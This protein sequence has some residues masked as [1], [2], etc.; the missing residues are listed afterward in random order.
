MGTLL[1]TSAAVQ[2]T[3]ASLVD[4]TFS[5]KRRRRR[6]HD[7]GEV[8]FRIFGFEASGSDVLAGL[9]MDGDCRGRLSV[10]PCK[11]TGPAESATKALNRQAPRG[12]S[13]DG[14]LHLRGLRCDQFFHACALAGAATTT[15][16][17]TSMA[18][19]N[20][21]S[22]AMEMLT[23]MEIQSILKISRAALFVLR[24]SDPAF[25]AP[26]S[27]GRH[28]RWTRQSIEEWIASRTRPAAARATK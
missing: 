27:V 3:V 7:R 25:P 6:R 4:R 12:S 16:R 1:E 14:I 28:D 21:I 8:I 17:D 10:T 26:I 5:G 23:L 9:V 13:S 11:K 15:K 18:T 20:S 24:K 22:N 19:Q 2:W